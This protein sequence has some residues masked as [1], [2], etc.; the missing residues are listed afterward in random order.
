MA[1]ETIEWQILSQLERAKEKGLNLG[2][3]HIPRLF[4]PSI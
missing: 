2:V 3:R 4:L 1:N